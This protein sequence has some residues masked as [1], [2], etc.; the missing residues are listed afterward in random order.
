MSRC[1]CLTIA[2]KRE[3]YGLGCTPHWIQVL[4]VTQHAPWRTGV[5]LGV[6]GFLADVLL[7]G[8]DAPNR[9]GTL[10]PDR[11]ARVAMGRVR[12][13]RLGRPKTRWN[14]FAGVL[15]L[16]GRDGHFPSFSVVDVERFPEEIEAW[17]R[18][19]A[20]CQHRERTHGLR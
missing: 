16:Y 13:D 4:K 14:R 7:S 15:Q 11:L 18:L 12:R 6:D 10:W 5:L 17:H 20:T 9:L 8:A 1:K 19:P 3:G 2:S